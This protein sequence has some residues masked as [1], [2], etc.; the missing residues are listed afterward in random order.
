MSQGKLRIGLAEQTV[1]VALAQASLLHEVSITASNRLMVLGT[2]CGC[3]QASFKDPRL[4]TPSGI[5]QASP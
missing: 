4:W 3:P 1:L 5:V 2:D